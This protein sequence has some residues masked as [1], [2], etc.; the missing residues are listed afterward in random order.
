MRLTGWKDSPGWASELSASAHAA[1]R[2]ISLADPSSL[3]VALVA[4]YKRTDN[5]CD[6]FQAL[7]ARLRAV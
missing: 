3:T 1:R 6:A 4:A 5:V 2:N 7:Q